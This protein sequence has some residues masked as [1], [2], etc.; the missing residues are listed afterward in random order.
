LAERN[1]PLRPFAP[2]RRTHGRPTPR[3]SGRDV[4]RLRFPGGD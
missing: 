1:R 4:G 3:R 2:P